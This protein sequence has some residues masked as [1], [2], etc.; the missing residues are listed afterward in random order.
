[1]SCYCL[2]CC[3][4]EAIRRTDII[5]SFVRPTAA[6]G[7]SRKLT[8][9]W[10]RVGA[11]RFPTKSIRFRRV[12]NS[13]HDGREGC[14]DVRFGSITDIEDGWRNVRF[15]SKSRHCYAV[16]MLAGRIST[17]AR[18]LRRSIGGQGLRGCLKPSRPATW[19][20]RE[21]PPLFLPLRRRRFQSRL[22]CCR[23][24][25]EEFFSYPRLC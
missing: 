1:M 22:S 15:T 9:A 6:A 3:V 12:S 19:G 16:V 8:S 24:S 4:H 2:V 11:R 13:K 10:M 14:P 7:P 23:D 20:V 18:P 25:P 21:D 5:S 17:P